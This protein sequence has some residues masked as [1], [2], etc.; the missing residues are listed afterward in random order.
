MGHFI[1]ITVRGKACECVWTGLN[2]PRKYTGV[3][4]CKNGKE[5]TSFLKLRNLFP[6][7]ETVDISKEAQNHKIECLVLCSV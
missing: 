5:S 3:D 7:G 4:L 1:W 6:G 2:W